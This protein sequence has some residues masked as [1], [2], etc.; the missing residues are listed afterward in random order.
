MISTMA[1]PPPPLPTLDPEEQQTAGPLL[2]A[3]ARGLELW[4]RQQCQEVDE[5]E[6]TLQGSVGQLL[7]GHLQGVHL[8]ARKVVFQNLSLERVDLCSDPIQLR[9]GAVLR[10]QPLR[11]DHP[12][13]VRGA[14][15]LSG[16]GLSRTLATSQWQALGDYLCEE[17]MGVTPLESVKLLDERIILQSHSSPE[18]NRLD[19]ETQMVLTSSGLQLRPLD[20]RPPLPLAMDE[21]IQLERAEV[22]AGLLELAGEALVQP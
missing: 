14:V 12:F 6:I 17:L 3:V 1:S 7:R 18:G 4:L 8:H 20:G 5:L 22:R 10:G 19:V 13:R 11:L 21:A 9:M 2:R 15:L 16:E